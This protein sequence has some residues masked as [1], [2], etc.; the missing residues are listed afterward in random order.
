MAE[1]DEEWCNVVQWWSEEGIELWKV[2]RRKWRNE[3]E[4]ERKSETKNSTR[5][6][7]LRL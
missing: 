1:I 5:Q 3:R 6:K 2:E 7:K 4:R